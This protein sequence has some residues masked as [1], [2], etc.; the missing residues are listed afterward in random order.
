MVLAMVDIFIV[1]IFDV[2]Y[3]SV[4]LKG[5]LVFAVEPA[6]TEDAN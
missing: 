3:L 2:N 1:V 5:G 6:L 4:Y